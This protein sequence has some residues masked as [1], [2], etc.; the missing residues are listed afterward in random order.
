MDAGLRVEQN[1]ASIHRNGF[2]ACDALAFARKHARTHMVR[3]RHL[4]LAPG[5]V[6]GGQYRI[7]AFLAGG[8]MCG[9]Y[10]ARELEPDAPRLLR[11]FSPAV[12]SGPEALRRF[13]DEGSRL[14]AVSH[15][16]LNPVVGLLAEPPTLAMNYV[17]GPGLAA[18]L[19]RWNFSVAEAVALV[20]PILAALG[21]AHE[22]GIF[23]LGVR[24]ERI[25]LR[26]EG[27]VIVGLGIAHLAAA[28][29]GSSAPPALALQAPAYRSPEQIRSPASVDARTD[30]FAMG[31]ILYELLAGRMAFGADTEAGLEKDILAGRIQAPEH[32]R[33]SL[34]PA[35]CAV[36]RQAL[37]PDP[38]ARF[39]DCGSFREALARAVPPPPAPASGGEESAGGSGPGPAGPPGSGISRLLLKV[40]RWPFAG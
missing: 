16:N 20:E 35:L 7:E 8:T 15:P 28:A 6:L 14:Q 17:P 3:T 30:V 26:Q 21:V 19:T 22:R 29:A 25:V 24:P 18:A 34:P 1:S 40:L 10:R 23:H 12:V 27:P 38:M 39:P 13:L 5:T 9:L 4:K 31:A 36:V 11:V 32:L 37:A 2:L 33:A